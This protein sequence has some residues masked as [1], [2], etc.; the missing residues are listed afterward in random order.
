MEVYRVLLS[1]EDQIHGVRLRETIEQ[2]SN[3]SDP[4]IPGRVMNIGDGDQVEIFCQVKD[5]EQLKKF[6]ETIKKTAKEKLFVKIESE[7][8]PANDL[9]E[10]ESFQEFEVI[11]GDQ[12]EEID[13]AIRGAERLFIKLKD[14]IVNFIKIRENRKLKGLEYSFKRMKGSLQPDD[15][16]RNYKLPNRTALDEFLAEPFDEDLEKTCEEIDSLLDEFLEL[17]NDRIDKIPPNK[18]TELVDLIKT[19]MTRVKELQRKNGAESN[20]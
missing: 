13:L 4:K 10:W 12:L 5:E 18:V 19:A 14:S 7:Y 20:I 16:S 1:S 8:Y 6:I 11:R 9:K 17:E 3:S 2:I 15:P